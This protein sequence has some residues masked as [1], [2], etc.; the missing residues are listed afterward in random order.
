MG[1]NSLGGLISWEYA[2]AHPERVDKMILIDAAG[3]PS[4]RKDPWVFRLARTP[5]LNL[6]VRYVTPVSFI[7]NNL[8]QVYAD[9]RK[10]SQ[11]LIDRY[12]KMTLRAGNRQAFIDRSSTQSEVHHEQIPHI[13]NPTL[14]QWGADD[15]WIPLSR[16]KRFHEDLPHSELIIYENAGHV[17]MEEIPEQTVQ[18]ALRFLKK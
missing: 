10:I 5:I 11:D 9:D 4:E 14:I 6:L 8:E 3:Y 17:P 7:E 1:G 18:D 2:L 16:G 12:Y 15:T 13:Q